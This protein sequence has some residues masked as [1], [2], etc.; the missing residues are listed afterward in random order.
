MYAVIFK[1]EINEIDQLYS[2]TA[3]RMRELAIN[4]Y[5]CTEFTSCTEGAFEIAISYWPSR[6]HIKAWKSNPE[7]RQ[8]QKLGKSRWYKSYQ[9]QVV[10]VLNQYVSSKAQID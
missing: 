7:H 9:V 8:A 4:E 3:D 10:E 6:E 2:D 1:A 5:G